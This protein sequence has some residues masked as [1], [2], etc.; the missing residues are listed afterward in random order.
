MARAE[1]RP[2]DL[3]RIMPA[4]ES[5]VISWMHCNSRRLRL[6]K[7]MPVY[8]FAWNLL[9]WSVTVAI[10]YP[11]MVPWSMLAYK[12]WHGA[13][14]IDEEMKEELLSRA[15]RVNGILFFTAPIFILFDYVASDENWLG[16]PPGYVHI[17]FLILFVAF[18][19]WMMMYYFSMEDFFQGLMLTILHL[20]LPATLLFLIW[21]VITWNPLFEYIRGWLRMPVEGTA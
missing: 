1:S 16:L 11:L 2:W 8:L 10:L 18:A 17:V 15:L 14:P 4:W 3:I 21:L 7:S 20:Y 6:G 13:K 9:A 12:I 5:D 19:A